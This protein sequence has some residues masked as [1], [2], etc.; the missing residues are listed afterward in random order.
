VHFFN[1]A[2][3]KSLL[4]V[5]AASLEKKFGSTDISIITGLGSQLPV[6]SATS[7][8]GLFSTVGIP[9]LAGF[10]SKL[11]IIIA[12]FS[13][14]KAVYAWIALL[15]SVLTLAYFLFMERSVFF[16]KTDSS[17]A[18]KTSVPFGLKFCEILLASITVGLGIATPF[19]FND[20]II[21]QIKN[22]IH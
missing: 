18:E 1:H 19:I 11:I 13:A 14:Q 16:I 21:V 8:I 20:Q 4:F 5:N 12:L 2:I 17:L 10:W 7:L 9:P 6:T 22:F 3:F 15:A